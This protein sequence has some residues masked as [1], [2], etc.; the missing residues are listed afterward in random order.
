MGEKMLMGVHKAFNAISRGV[1]RRGKL[2]D[3]VLALDRN[4]RAEIAFAK[5]RD[6]GLQLFEAARELADQGIEADRDGERQP[7]Q[8]RWKTQ[9]VNKV[10][11]PFLR[12]GDQSAAVFQGETKDA[13]RRM[14]D[15]ATMLMAQD[16]WGDVVC[17]ACFGDHFP[18]RRQQGKVEAASFAPE[19][20]FGGKRLAISVGRQ[21]ALGY[22]GGRL[23]PR[24]R[25]TVVEQAEQSGRHPRQ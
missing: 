23:R 17:A 14:P 3:L 18:G 5:F 24:P 11:A 7:K 19:C 6:P 16:R 21:E 8:G 10:K 1:E 22:V 25:R 9:A 12:D 20:E 15:P 13:S 4:A 2:R